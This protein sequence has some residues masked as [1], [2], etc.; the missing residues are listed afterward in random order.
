MLWGRGQLLRRN[1][2]GTTRARVQYFIEPY[3]GIA[4][5]KGAPQSLGIAVGWILCDS[6]GTHWVLDAVDSVG[7]T[8]DGWI[9]VSV[10]RA[11]SVDA[12]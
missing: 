5:I 10:R 11:S 6:E 7:P 2:H 1:Q 4:E 8:E 12:A 9:K 3:E